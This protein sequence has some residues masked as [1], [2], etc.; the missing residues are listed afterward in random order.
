MIKYIFLSVILSIFILS[1]ADTGTV[2]YDY[3]NEDST[4]GLTVRPANNLVFTEADI[5]KAKVFE[6]LIDT[7]EL[8]L[9]GID[10]E[11]ADYGS[12]S[13]V[14]DPKFDNIT[15]MQS[16]ANNGVCTI[17]IKMT[18]T[19]AAGSS[20]SIKLKFI[21]NKDNNAE[22]NSFKYHKLTFARQ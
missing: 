18:S 9:I 20:G 22:P 13:F 15:C 6:L 2:V 3:N 16:V 10:N 11:S 17:S 14:N 5:D 19:A 7:N 12:G 8:T 4:V 21:Y 1:C